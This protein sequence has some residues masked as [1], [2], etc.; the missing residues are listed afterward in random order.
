M[1]LNLPTILT[2]V[3]RLSQVQDATADFVYY[4]FKLKVGVGTKMI[5]DSHKKPNGKFSG[6]S[7]IIFPREA[8]KSGEFLTLV[9]GQTGRHVHYSTLQKSGSSEKFLK[10]KFFSYSVIN[11]KKFCI[12]HTL[13]LLSRNLNNDPTSV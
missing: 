6:S 13:D 8:K 5:L 1:I 10:N 11:L 12:A 9:H 4:K 3:G 7:G 2:K